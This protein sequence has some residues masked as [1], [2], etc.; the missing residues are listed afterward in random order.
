[1][2]GEHELLDLNGHGVRL[3]ALHV[4]HQRLGLA[5]RVPDVQRAMDEEGTSDEQQRR[6]D[7]LA[8]RHLHGCHGSLP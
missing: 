3:L 6:K 1:L 4:D 7:Q 5:P 2:R 8:H